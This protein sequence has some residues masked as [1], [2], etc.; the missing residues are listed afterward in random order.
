MRRIPSGSAGVARGTKDSGASSGGGVGGG[1]SKEVS[2]EVE[3]EDP[4]K[5]GYRQGLE[6][7][8]R[9][10]RAEAAK[11]PDGMQIVNDLPK[12]CYSTF[13]WTTRSTN[14]DHFLQKLT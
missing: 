11:G 2:G 14:F 8:K 3:Q 4:F 10:G 7:G 9:V 5:L 1:K 12:R 6:E 13:C